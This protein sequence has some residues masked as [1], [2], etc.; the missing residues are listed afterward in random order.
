[1]IQNKVI[2]YGGNLCNTLGLIRSL[3]ERGI[4]VILMLEPCEKSHRFVDY[5][6]Y[7]TKVHY[8]DTSEQVIDVLKAEYWH[9][10][11]KPIILCGG[12]KSVC[13]LDLYYDE[14]KDHVFM[15]NTGEQGRINYFMD[16]I[17]TFPLAEQSGFSIIRTWTIANVS[18]LP[19]DITFPC[20]IKGNNSTHCSK[21]DMVICQNYDELK[22]NLHEGIEYLIQ[23]YIEKDYELDI[24]GISYNHGKNVYAPAAV[25]KI[26]ESLT[27][28]S[29]YICL[30]EIKKYES[31][32]GFSINS[33]LASIG[34]E[35]L[36]SIEI[37]CKDDK[38][39]FL[40]INLRNDGTCYLYT[41]AG[42]NYPYLWVKYCSGKF[43]DET[44]LIEEKPYT[45]FTLMSEGDF[46]NLLEGK[47]KKLVW[48]RQALT[49]DAHFIF[50]K[51]DLKP[52]LRLWFVHFRQMCKKIFRKNK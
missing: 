45:P 46:A 4:N 26:R 29:D 47:V 35:G 15:F 33:L 34:Y 39:Y 37:M 41:A 30:E 21:G 48:V 42:C 25:R 32:Y 44:D 13:V 31:L 49:A 3:G 51:K 36:F 12:D 28:Q 20:I 17:N 14:L 23:E 2:V 50:N 18:N 38:A 5:S 9:E 8:L 7:I 24:V 22:E 19:Q 40:E 10:E 16:K 52:F 43:N 6:K 11:H 1:M 27:R